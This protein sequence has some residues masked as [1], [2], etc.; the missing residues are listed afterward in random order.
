MWLSQGLV[1]RRLFW[2]GSRTFW[3]VGEWTGCSASSRIFQLGP[4]Y[5]NPPVRGLTDAPPR[6][7]PGSRLRGS[8]GWGVSSALG[9]DRLSTFSPLPAEGLIG[10]TC[11]AG[12]RPCSWYATWHISILPLYRALFTAI[13]ISSLLQE[14]SLSW[15]SS[16]KPSVAIWG[17]VLEVSLVKCPK[18]AL[19]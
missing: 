13:S 18:E 14:G 4:R 9:A 15:P 19:N 6:V 1:L 12:G 5:L 11:S 10:W 16:T 3:K 17:S 7:L 2:I 8:W